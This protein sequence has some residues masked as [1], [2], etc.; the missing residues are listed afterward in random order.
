MAKGNQSSKP[1]KSLFQGISR[2]FRKGRQTIGRWLQS[3]VV[4]MK[5]RSRYNQAGFVLPTVTMVLL[6]VV[7]LSLTIT[8]RAFDRAKDARYSRVSEQAFNAAA[9][10]LDRANAKIRQAFQEVSQISDEEIYN[11]L[12]TYRFG[13]EEQVQV[14]YDVNGE[15]G[16][17]LNGPD[18]EGA[19]L[20]DNEAIETAWRFPFDTDNNG[21]F[22]SF[23]VYGIFFRTPT[24]GEVR[25]PLDSRTLPLP[26]LALTGE[27][28]CAAY[29]GGVD[30]LVTDEG[31][32]PNR[33]KFKKS[34]FA[35]TVTVPVTQ[36]IIDD[37]GLGEDYE[38]NDGSPGFAPLESQQDWSIKPLNGVVYIDDLEI[39]PGP[40]FNLNVGLYAE[41]NLITSPFDNNIR[42]FQISGKDSCFYDPD[43]SKIVVGGNVINGM[44]GNNQNQNPVD[45][46]LFQ[47]AD[48]DI[49]EAQISNANQSTDNSAFQAMYNDRAYRERLEHLVKVQL[50][51]TEEEQENDA[52]DPPTVKK[53]V[54]Q[55][56][57]EENVPI[58]DARRTE[59]ERYFKA[60]LRKVPI[61]E[62]DIDYETQ[63]L[64]DPTGT[65]DE[66]AVPDA[67][68]DL[69]EAVNINE[70]QLEATEPTEETQKTGI[71]TY[72][73]DRVLVGNNQPAL[74]YVN[75]S[76]EIAEEELGTWT[77][78]G[79]PRERFSRVEI[80]SDAVDKA[81]GGF[82][83]RAAA[84]LP[85]TYIEGVG[86]LRVVTGAGIY[87][88]ANSFLKRPTGS[89]PGNV[90]TDFYD[91]PATGDTERFPIVWPDTMPMSDPNAAGA[92]G[93]L[94]MRATAVYHYAQ[95]AINPSDGDNDQEPI[96]CVSSYYDPSTSATATDPTISNNGIV[97]N[98]PTTGRPAGA[99]TAGA[100]GRLTGGEQD[101]NDQAD[102]VFP[103]GRF[104]NQ[105]LREAL[106]V[107]ENE[108]SINQKAAI[109]ATLCAIGINDNTL[110]P[111]NSI[112]PDNAIYE[113]AFLDGRQVKAVDADDTETP[114][115]ETF[116]LSSPLGAGAANLSKDYDLPLE[117]RQ[118]LE[119]RATV[120][121]LDLLRN[122]TIASTVGIDELDEEYL[123]PLS[124]LIYASR[125]DALPDR[126]DR[127][128][129]AAGDGIDEDLSK[130]ISPV[131]YKLDPTRRPNGILLINGESLGRDN[132]AAANIE[133]DVL[134]EKGLTLVSNLPVY[135]QGDFNIHTQ[136]E[137]LDQLDDDFGNFY[138]RQDLNPD[139][140]CRE[141]DPI[142][143]E[144][145]IPCGTGDNWR[146][147]TVLS[148]A[149]TLLSDNFRFGYRNEGDF[150]LRNNAGTNVP[151]NAI[152]I[153][154]NFGTPNTGNERTYGI[155]LNGDGQVEDI[156]VPGAEITAKVAR[157]LN[158]FNGYNDFAVNGL[159]S[160]ATNFDVGPVTDNDYRN[161]N[162]NAVNSSYFNNFITPIQRRGNFSEYVMEVCPKLPVSACE[163]GDW[164]IRVNN[165]TP[166]ILKPN[167]PAEYVKLTDASIAVGDLLAGTTVQAPADDLQRLPRRVAFLRN[168]DFT[169]ALDG[170]NQPVPL[171]VNGANTDC[172]ATTA[173][174]QLDGANQ[175]CQTGTPQPADNAL[176]FQTN[177]NGNRN[178]GA[179]N[180]LWYYD[181]DNK[182]TLKTF[183]APTVQQPL[184]VPVLQIHA[185]T[186]QPGGGGFPE[187]DQV[188]AGQVTRWL[189]LAEDTEY[190]LVLASGDVP[191]RP[192]ETNGGLQNLARFLENWESQDK[193]ATISGSFVQSGRGE[194]ATAPFLGIFDA[195]GIEIF[196]ETGANAVY[197]IKN[198][199]KR[200]GYFNPPA[201]N[202]GFDVGLLTQPPDYFSRKFARLEKDQEG[203]YTIQQ[204]FR[205]VGKDDPWVKGL[206]CGKLVEVEPN[207]P[208]DPDAGP[209]NNDQGNAV[210]DSVRGPLKCDQKT[211]RTN[212]YDS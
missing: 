89:A 132:N 51:E 67:W 203:N 80:L 103:D 105:P 25:T 115:D 191:G 58:A 200:T 54:A 173:T 188:G 88:P 18:G 28:D 154:Y 195:G 16:I 74:E 190:N 26:S 71:E 176:W 149:I 22:D 177:N 17:E 156:D 114:V 40:E 92:K 161:N 181:L 4:K 38:A 144:L 140:A 37:E 118:P 147:A 124:G 64:L 29:S 206:L 9:P 198:S 78:T 131:D 72:L 59:L 194:Y 180:P 184:L 111:N 19:T 102:Y 117:D 90:G 30:S 104:A 7:L 170:N 116:T 178:W 138:N 152:A 122:T 158:G 43:L 85:R 166:P 167:D 68:A 121:D 153:G 110:T 55:L 86:G 209:E 70:A 46:D 137:F 35:Y 210:P 63:N 39:T 189:P 32:T 186:T 23:S 196:G 62:V 41:S 10:A 93:D 6:V 66:L 134:K 164:E 99:A 101:L 125:D 171:G 31:L 91:D 150:D 133:E 185:T 76:W 182:G 13:D 162:N 24:P 20:K 112:I 141:G 50:G 44:V 192:D 155:D 151:E 113:T 60:R 179:N 127:Q 100:D 119:I 81:R 42:I 77:D 169:L 8:F 207:D 135:I 96:A 208:D 27:Q 160:D 98:P 36:Q 148:D 33:G 5:R 193:T 73:G 87:D 108:R 183:T 129:N 65:G 211:N 34:I 57:N 197:N 3:W 174:V 106:Q 21:E 82:W 53:L 45:I 202:W 11:I 163:P 12:R 212:V 79:E 83:E 142:R 14:R 107:A 120:L 199:R 172:F 136:E 123:L 187:G 94:V 47:G 139:F 2:F 84:R 126:S 97:Y 157:Q 128:E 15:S 205:E 175:A 75:G 109:D 165:G 204:L 52:N 61:A 143:A 56:V 168:A 130:A 48:A 159:S 201:R 69:P 49:A 146:P 145:N 95:D 1:F